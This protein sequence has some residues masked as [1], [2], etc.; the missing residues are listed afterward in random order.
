[1]SEDQQTGNERKENIGTE[2]PFNITH[3][4]IK[5]L[6]FES[7]S[8]PGLFTAAETQSPNI[9]IDVQVEAQQ[10]AEKRFQVVLKIEVNTTAGSSILFI[11]ELEYA[12][13]VEV[14]E[15]PEE[16]VHAFI[17]IEVPRLL[18]PFARSIVANV[19]SE[20]G[21]PPLLIQPVDF[22]KM[23]RQTAEQGAQDLEEQ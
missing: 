13:I 18:F 16:H 23:Y 17:M 1:M 4:Y 2:I 5:D 19:V 11:M 14:G 3:Q 7:P 10:I 8:A 9:N 12:G 6:S 22:V 15:L 20:G 21:F